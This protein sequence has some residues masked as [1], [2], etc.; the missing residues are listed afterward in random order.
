[1]DANVDSATAIAQRL[2]ELGEPLYRKVEPTGYPSKNSEW[3]NSSAL[4]G[5]MNFA[6]ALTQGKLHGITVPADRLASNDDPMALAK[7]L[8]PAPLSA[9]TRETIAKALEGQTEQQQ[10]ALVAGLLLGS[11]EFQRR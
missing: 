3:M 7:Q 2:N 6:L 5:R 10:Q 11:P 8:L 4:L 9:A 1:M